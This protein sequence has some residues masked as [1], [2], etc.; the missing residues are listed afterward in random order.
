MNDKQ[1]CSSVLVRSELAMNMTEVIRKKCMTQGD[2]ATLF[3]V[4]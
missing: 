3:G 4:T 2:I 1:R